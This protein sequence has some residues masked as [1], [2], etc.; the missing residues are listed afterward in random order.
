[1]SQVATEVQALALDVQADVGGAKDV[2]SWMEANAKAWRHLDFALVVVRF[3]L[4]QA[5]SGIRFGIQRARIPVFGISFARRIF[6][7]FFLQVS[8]VRQQQAAQRNAPVGAVDAPAK[9]LLDQGWQVSRVVQ[10]GMREDHR[11]DRGRLDGK[12]G[13]VALAQLLVALE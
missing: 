3:E 10:M 1:S 12:R 2:A 9:S 5:A 4:L 13:P 7:F 6:G 11:V 8:A